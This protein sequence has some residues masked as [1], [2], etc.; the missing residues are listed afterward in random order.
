MTKI[1]ATCPLCAGVEIT[2]KELTL[3]VGGS[4]AYYEFSCPK[5]TD[6]IRRELDHN[7]KAIPEL[8]KAGVNLIEIPLE[9]L[10]VHDGPVITHDDI[11]EFHELLESCDDLVSLIQ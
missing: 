9:A 5:C 3:V 4:S 1:A 8:I 7:D 6:H 2:P 10:E 11:L